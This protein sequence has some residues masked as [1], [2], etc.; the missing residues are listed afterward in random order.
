[1]RPYL[2]EQVGRVGV[3]AVSVFGLLGMIIVMGVWLRPIFKDIQDPSWRGREAAA[4]RATL[5]AILPTP[6]GQSVT[7]EEVIVQAVLPTAQEVPMSTAVP[8]VLTVQGFTGQE[9]P[10]GYLRM[11]AVARFSRYWPPLGGTNCFTDCEL[12]ADGGRVDEAI[13]EGQRVLACPVELLLGTRVEWPPESGVVWTCRDRGEGI[14]FYYSE[15]G[16]PVYWLDFLSENDFVDYGSYIQV[17][18]FVPC[19][20]LG[21]SC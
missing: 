21:Q 7:I 18:I 2:G 19:E 8:Q 12:F 6:V 5:R 16:L 4:A 3:E 14:N 20:Q 17:D 13:A 1:M 15:N 10:Q 9:L 11:R